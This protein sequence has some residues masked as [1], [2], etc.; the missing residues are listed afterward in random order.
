M[1]DE[2]NTVTHPI[3]SSV[4]LIQLINDLGLCS[5]NPTGEQIVN[6]AIAAQILAKKI[7]K[8]K[9]VDDREYLVGYLLSGMA[10]GEVVGALSDGLKVT[11]LGRIVT[12]G[13]GNLS[14]GFDSFNA[15]KRELGPAGEGKVWHHIVEQSQI[16]KSGFK[17]TQINNT[18]NII[19]VDNATHAKISGYYSSKP[20]FAK[21]MT[22][23]DWLAGQ[24]YEAQYK[25]GLE[26]MARFGV[27]K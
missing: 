6:R 22:V 19:A 25:F 7:G 23:R 13:P 16:S 20:D 21:G 4:Q 8:L 11:K 12:E 18:E 5:Q 26:V 2:W 24:S 3:D 15:L 1:S 17:S 10:T 9:N 27:G 14:K